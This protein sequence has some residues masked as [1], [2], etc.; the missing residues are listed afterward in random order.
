MSDS[1]A[2]VAEAATKSVGISARRTLDELECL[3]A[4][5]NVRLA[6][7]KTAHAQQGHLE[8]L[9]ENEEGIRDRLVRQIMAR[10]RTIRECATADDQWLP[11]D[12]AVG[13]Y[14]PE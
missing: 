4:R 10:R 9:I 1:H 2:F 3:L 13:P 8:A 12:L 14:D 6:H 7:L 11:N 5:S